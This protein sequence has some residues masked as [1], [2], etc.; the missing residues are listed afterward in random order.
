MARSNHKTTSK[1]SFSKVRFSAVQNRFF[2]NFE[3]MYFSRRDG[4]LNAASWGEIERTMTDLIAYPGI[5][6]WWETR[7]HWHTNEFVR[8][9]DEI[10]AKAN[11]PKAYAT[12]TIYTASR[13][14]N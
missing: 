6:Q 4:I 9:V 8:I 5:R 2:K 14:H 10:I 11:E 7:K 1:G 3:G 13:D 12:P